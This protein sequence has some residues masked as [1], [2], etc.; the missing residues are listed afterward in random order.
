MFESWGDI[1]IYVNGESIL[2]G[3]RLQKEGNEVEISFPSLNRH[4][5]TIFLFKNSHRHPIE[6]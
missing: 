3:V 2:G 1:E 6:C 5:G 4:G